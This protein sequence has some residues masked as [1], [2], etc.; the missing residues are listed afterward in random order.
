LKVALDIQQ[1]LMLKN[2]IYKYI[3]NEIFRNFTT[4]LLTFTAIVWVVRAVN[5]LDLMVEDGY[6]SS[7]YF[8]YSILNITNIMTRFVPLAFLLSLTIS[9][10]KL[11]RQQELLILWTSGLAKIKIA[12]IFLQIA[13]F[14]TLFQ[15][16]LSLFVTPFLL[17]KSRSLLSNTES[18]QV[19]NVLKSNDFSDSYRGI[20]FYIESKSVNNELLNI[21]IKDVDGNLNAVMDQVQTNRNST[22]VAEKGFIVKDKLILFDGVIQ[23]LNQKNEIKN[24]QFKKIELS[25]NKIA[26]R[27]IKQPKVQEISNKLLLTCIFDK[28][29][30]LIM[31][32]CSKDYQ[33]EA[34]QTLSKRLG[35][36]LYIPLISI[37][38][39]F[40]LIYKKEKKYN[41][42]K[43]YI[44]FILS[45]VILIFAE[46]LLKYT[47]FSLLAASSYFI[48]PLVISFLFYIYLYKKIMTEKIIK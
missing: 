22:I 43:K 39:S 16:V 46:I 34:V 33:N 38:T 2:K 24:I 29:N 26:T 40:L 36:P 25:L 23:S 19:A 48:L 21:F 6:S 10:I 44:L 8:K 37:I 30:N 9:I 35:A 5:F 27:T 4:I 20:T 3:F 13:F 47:G 31:N 28:K 17:N 12:N 1:I 42:L 11:E 32:T 14:V 7:I 45:F 41:F 15:L 18:L